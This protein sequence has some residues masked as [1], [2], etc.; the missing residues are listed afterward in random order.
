MR[1]LWVF[2]GIVVVVLTSVLGCGKHKISLPARL[3]I[4]SAYGEPSPSTGAHYLQRGETVTATCGQTPYPSA[5]PQSGTRYIC[6]GY[7]ATGSGL[8]GAND[9]TV[10]FT[11]T[12]DTTITWQWRTEHKLSVEVEPAG[13]GSVTLVG[14]GDPNGYYTEWNAVQLDTTAAA[15]FVFV[16]W[17]G[18]VSGTDNPLT[19][20]MN[21]PKNIKAVFSD[22][23]AIATTSLPEGEV[24]V[25]YSA[26]V[27]T[28]G[29]N[30]P[31]TFSDVNNV[32]AQYGLTLNNRGGT[33]ATITGVP[34]QATPANGVTVTLQVTDGV[35]AQLPT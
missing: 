34:T 23:L 3:T 28:A 1:R 31:C 20:T 24:N 35:R 17:E 22:M 16:R 8:T 29:S 5:D 13:A 14:G 21:A 27:Q 26:V 4:V 33:I 6:T 32:F 7:T 18:N 11:I 30:G 19:V 15:V 12:E 25:S 9:T 10:T 2:V